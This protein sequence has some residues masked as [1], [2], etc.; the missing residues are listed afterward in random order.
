MAAIIPDITYKYGD[1]LDIAFELLKNP[2]SDKIKKSRK[3]WNLD[4][5]KNIDGKNLKNTLL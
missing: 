5:D 1:D 4:V 3:I 2:N